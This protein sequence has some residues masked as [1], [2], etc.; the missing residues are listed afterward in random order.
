MI[1]T[2]NYFQEQSWTIL[3]IFRKYLQKITIVIKINQDLQLLQLWKI[4]TLSAVSDS[5]HE[6][7]LKQESIPVGCDRPLANRTILAATRCQ[8]QWGGPMSGRGPVH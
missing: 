8:Y 2:L 7:N 3:H 4:M 5:S 1:V 6:H